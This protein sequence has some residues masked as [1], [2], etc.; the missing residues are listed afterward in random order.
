MKTR[1]IFLNGI[2]QLQLEKTSE[3]KQL[4]L[5]SFPI[6]RTVRQVYWSTIS[7]HVSLEIAHSAQNLYHSNALK[8]LTFVPII[9]VSCK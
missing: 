8:Q 6:F 7:K 3:Y 5:F 2:Y 9:K 4:V 1:I